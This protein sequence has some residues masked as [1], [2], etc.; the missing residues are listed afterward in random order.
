MKPSTPSTPTSELLDANALL[1]LVNRL[2]RDLYPRPA[3]MP[4]RL[5][6][7]GPGDLLVLIFHGP[8][9]TRRIVEVD[10]VDECGNL[11]V[12]GM[13]F[14]PSGFRLDAWRIA[15]QTGSVGDRAVQ[16][17]DGWSVPGWS[18]RTPFHLPAVH[19]G[20]GARP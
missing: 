18:P 10:Q 6:K 3:N 2:E 20:V 5:D 14:A 9:V 13:W 19:A 17:I 15:L 12:D 7:A 4:K 11:L 1:A 8:P 16:P